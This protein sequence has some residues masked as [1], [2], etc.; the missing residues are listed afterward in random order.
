MN[1]WFIHLH[2]SKNL[3]HLIERN[4]GVWSSL[5]SILLYEMTLVTNAFL[6]P[7]AVGIMELAMRTFLHCACRGIA[8]YI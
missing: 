7:A 8:R 5:A 3:A 4:L 2:E 1:V 6:L